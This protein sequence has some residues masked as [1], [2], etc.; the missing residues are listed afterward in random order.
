VDEWT[1]VGKS[2]GTLPITL[3][4]AVKQ[5]N[6]EDLRELLV[7]V[8]TPGNSRYGKHLTSEEA[9]KMV[10]PSKDS[11]VLIKKWIAS[12]LGTSVHVESLTANSDVLK[13]ETS[14]SQ[15][16]KLLK[17]EYYDYKGVTAYG[18][19][20][21]VTRVKM[22]TNYEVPSFVANYLDFVS[23]THRFPSLRRRVTVRSDGNVGAAVTPEFLRSLYNVGT[24]EG[25]SGVNNSQGVASFQD[26]LYSKTDLSQFW[27]TYK[28]DPCTVVDVPAGERSGDHLEAELDTQYI[29]SMGEKI[30][31]QV[32]YTNG[33]N[34]QDSLLQWT[35]DVIASKDRPNLFSVSYG[36]VESYYGGA[37]I[38]RL[39]S[40]FAILGSLGISV[41]IASGDSGAGGGCAAGAAFEPDYPASSPYVTAVGGVSGGT[42]GQ[43]PVGETAWVD[44]GGGFSNYAPTQ[45]WQKAEVAAYLSETNALPDSKYYNSSGRGYPDIVAQ[46]VDFDIVV[47]G[48]TTGVSGTS[49]A[50][51][52]AAG[53]FALL[54]DL[55]VQ[56]KMAPLGFLN[57]FIYSTGRS[58]S[59]AFNDCSDG[60]NKGCG[61]AKGF[62]AAKGWDAASGYGSPNY[63][64]LKKYVLATGR[65]SRHWLRK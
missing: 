4:F 32:W 19:E 28:I 11:I 52:T 59:T 6:I 61:V 9:L 49:C 34:F 24:V 57:P 27:T 23:P 36:A 17:C 46:S 22:G 14:I 65:T 54:N 1:E 44:G 55:R 63:A 29:S 7:E 30:T 18:K 56:N 35:N 37:Y 2:E 64:V 47:D 12:K 13:I 20:I 31:M 48:K 45:S 5:Q 41:L 15:A 58:D 21:S 53:I 50:S 26:Q 10:A 42:A 25:A 51:P 33:L 39:N 62:S 8:S 38:D 60:Y 3:T 16:E 40:Q 43:T